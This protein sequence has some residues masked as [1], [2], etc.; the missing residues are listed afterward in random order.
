MDCAYV[1]IFRFLFIRGGLMF[2][3]GWYLLSP[4]MVCSLLRSLSDFLGVE[5]EM[6][7]RWLPAR[8]SG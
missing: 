6:R 8:Y 5:S 4:Y 3:M 7:V 1:Q 2:V